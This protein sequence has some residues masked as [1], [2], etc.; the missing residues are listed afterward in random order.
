MMTHLVRHFMNQGWN[1]SVNEN[2]DLILS[3]SNDRK[4]IK[5]FSVGGCNFQTE[6]YIKNRKRKIKRL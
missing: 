1:A 3:N 5:W 6:D 4:N 2:K